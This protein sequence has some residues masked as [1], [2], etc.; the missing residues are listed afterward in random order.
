MMAN[1]DLTKL[2]AEM[3][4]L[5]VPLTL[6]VAAGDKAVPPAQ[7]EEAATATPGASLVRVARLGHLAHEEDPKAFLSLIQAMAKAH[8]AA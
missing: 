5:R 6:V 7:G 8:P 3:A 1:W 2:G 4:G